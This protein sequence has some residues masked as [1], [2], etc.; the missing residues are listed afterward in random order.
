MKFT[1]PPSDIVFPRIEEEVL[2][3]WKQR[4]AFERSIEQ[5]SPERSFSF[6]DDPPFA[7]GLPHYGH[8]VDGTIKE[9]AASY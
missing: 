5:R 6:Y 9:V 3:R 8:L 1:S 4:R 7:T 2:E